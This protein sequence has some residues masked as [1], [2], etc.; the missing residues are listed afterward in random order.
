MPWFYY[1][2]RMLVR[3]FLFLLTRWEVR[4]IENVPIH[5]GVLIISNHLNLAD[6]PLL[7]ISF[8]RRVT[9]M[10]KRELFRYP[11]VSYIV[12]NVGAFPVHRGQLNRDA[13]RQASRVL[14]QGQ[15]LVIFPEGMRSRSG[16]LRQ[17]FPGSA[18]IALRCRVPV[19]PIGI[20]GSE[21]IKG[22]TW[23]VRR[24]RIT[25]NIGYPFYLLPVDGKLTGEKL[26]QYTDFM[27]W[28]VAG[29]LPSEY[30]GRY[31]GERRW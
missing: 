20:I 23:I 29:L 28:R 17:A 10:A 8:G 26:A 7:G 3:A 21:K 22:F 9:F 5:G 27:M 6:P 16:Q 24:P 2:A 11:V 1:L 13:L 31:A 14:E 25:V 12:R 30:Q 15:A 4:G 18:L 19:L